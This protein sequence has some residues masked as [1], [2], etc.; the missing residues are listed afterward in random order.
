MRAMGSRH[1]MMTMDILISPQGLRVIL[2]P[3][4]RSGSPMNV[5]GL[6]VSPV[7]TPPLQGDAHVVGIDT[8]SLIGAGHDSKSSRKS[9]KDA[10]IITFLAQA[11]LDALAPSP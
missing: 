6:I 4:V 8:T 5:H 1:T 7:C 9:C 2:T 10:N 11:I 3:P